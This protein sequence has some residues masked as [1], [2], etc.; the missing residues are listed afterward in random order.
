M[1]TSYST[2][3]GLALPVQGELSGTWGDTVN[4]YITNYLDSAVAGTQTLSTD[5]DVTLTKT[6]GTALGA[7]SSQYAIINCTGARTAQRTITAPAASKMYTIINATTGGFAVKIVGAGP[8]TGVTIAAGEKCFVVWTGSDFAKVTSQ[9]VPGDFTTIS[10]SGTISA[11]ANLAFSGTGNRITGDFSNA[12]VA[13]RVMFQTSTVNG[14]SIL[15]V[16]PNGTGTTT[17]L[18]LG[19]AAD[20]TNWSYLALNGTAT[21]ARVTSGISGTGS[22][23][24]MTFYTGGSERVRIDTFGTTNAGGYTGFGAATDCGIVTNNGISIGVNAG[25][26]N[27]SLH[28]NQVFSGGVFKAVS[29]GYTSNILFTGTSGM[30][31][32][33]GSNA[34]VAAGGTVTQTARLTVDVSGNVTAAAN[35]TAYSDERLKTNWQEFDADILSQLA[36]VKVG[37]YDRTDI[38]ATQV[39]VSAQS[40]QAVLPNAVNTGEDGMLSVAYGNAALSMCVMLAREVEALKAELKALKGA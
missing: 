38:D 28:W 1:A 30:W 2:L 10:A 19:N 8:T 12:T 18:V 27:C 15:G 21:D 13:N 24:P 26:S 20:P 29:A 36:N 40:L 39:G 23:L 33:Y 5:A 6:T 25:A 14:A 11:A 32:L 37:V 4:N 35:V 31:A 22:Y 3:L 34:S 7:T 16:I 9:G 17:G